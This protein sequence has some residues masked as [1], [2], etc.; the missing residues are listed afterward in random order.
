MEN[1]FSTNRLQ[2]IPETMLITLWAKAEETRK[3]PSN[4]LLYDEK[5]LEIIN[6]I[7]Y[8]FSKFKNEDRV[9]V[10]M[11]LIKNVKKVSGAK[12]GMVSY[13]GQKTIKQKIDKM[14][15]NELINDKSL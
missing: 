7:D 15:I 12:P 1:K 10:D 11:T 8:D 2:D 3:K 6:K 4:A 14:F 5:A 9:A 13:T